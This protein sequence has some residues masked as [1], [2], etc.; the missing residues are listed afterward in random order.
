[1]AFFCLFFVLL[2]SFVCLFNL[3]RFEKYSPT[4]SAIMKTKH[5]PEAAQSF[6]LAQICS[7]A[8]SSVALQLWWQWWMTPDSSS[9]GF[10]PGHWSLF[11]GFCWSSTLW[12]SLTEARSEHG[13]KQTSHWQP[14][15]FSEQLWG[16]L[17]TSSELRIHSSFQMKHPV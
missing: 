11:K 6:H 4:T 14:Y 8:L 17:L 7:C 12:R 9:S 15:P 5:I 16:H 1:M 13:C 3:G 2:V 10:S